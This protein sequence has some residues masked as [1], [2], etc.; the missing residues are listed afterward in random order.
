MRQV[1]GGVNS[2]AVSHVRSD[3]R[4]L[5]PARKAGRSGS[6]MAMVV[7]TYASHTFYSVE[8]DRAAQAD[9][10]FKEDLLT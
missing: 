1:Y 7:L 3:T 6:F 10:G 8:V 2:S 5:F 9:S 4:T